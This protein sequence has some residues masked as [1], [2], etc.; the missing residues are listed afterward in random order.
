M[1][2]PLLPCK[3]VP[4]LKMNNIP[5]SLL[6]MTDGERELKRT[7]RGRETQLAALVEKLSGYESE[8]EK[9]LSNYEQ[10]VSLST[11]L[12]ALEG[13]KSGKSTGTLV[14]STA[15]GEGSSGNG[16]L[17]SRS[18]ATAAVKTGVLTTDTQENGETVEP[19]RGGSKRVSQSQQGYTPGMFPDGTGRL[20][21]IV[22]V[23]RLTVSIMS[24]A[25]LLI[26]YMLS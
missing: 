2:F 18:T 10:L 13:K 9:S 16:L 5:Y 23:D 17:R 12:E 6:G 20:E 14:S 24:W 26:T 1:L 21:V 19:R 3:I 8:V 7:L 22:N 11:K 15:S 25:A 4:L